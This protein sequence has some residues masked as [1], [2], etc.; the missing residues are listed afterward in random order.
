MEAYKT[1]NPFEVQRILRHK[2]LA[3]TQKYIH[4]AEALADSAQEDDWVAAVAYTLDEYLKLLQRGFT[5][6]SDYGNP[7]TKVLKKRK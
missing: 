3:N 1:R 5:Y 4:W 7:E 2:S 6:V